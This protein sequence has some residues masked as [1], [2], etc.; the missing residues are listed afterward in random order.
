MKQMWVAFAL[1]NFFRKNVSVFIDNIKYETLK[2]AITNNNVSVML[3]L[4]ISGPRT[5]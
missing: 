2:L 4:S 1:T 3:I 5:V